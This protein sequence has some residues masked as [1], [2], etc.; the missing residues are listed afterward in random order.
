MRRIDER[1]YRAEKI[2]VL[3]AAIAS[4]GRRFFH[5]QGNIAR[6]E[7]DERG[8]VWWVDHYSGKQVYTHRQWLGRGFT[9]GGT[10][11]RLVCAFRDYIMTGAPVKRGHFGPWPEW[12]CDGDPWGYGED[13]EK[14]RVAAKE[15]CV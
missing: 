4:C 12:I 13:M 9:S 7:V 2:N 3:I 1:R 11:N 14:V 8:R 6:M 15:V 10:L 5:H